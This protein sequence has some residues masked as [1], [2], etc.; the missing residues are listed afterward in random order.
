MAASAK[1]EQ[2]M[3][4]SFWSDELYG[5]WNEQQGLLILTPLVVLTD[6]VCAT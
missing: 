3:L 4:L 6:I 5:C 1:W 2:W